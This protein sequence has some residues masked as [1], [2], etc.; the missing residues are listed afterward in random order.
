[1]ALRPEPI[2]LLHPDWALPVRAGF[3]CR[4]GGVSQGPY[5]SLNLGTH[6]GDD[7]QA[8]SENRRR[9]IAAAGLSAA[10]RWLSQVHGAQVVRADAVQSDRTAADAVWSDQPGAVCAVLVAD[11]VPILLAADQGECVAAVHAGWRGLVSGVI[12]QTLA[13]LPVTAARLQA[14]VGPCIGKAAYEVGPEVWQAVAGVSAA[15]KQTSAEKRHI[16]L[17][18]IAARRLQQA[19]VAQVQQAHACT[20]SNPQQF[21]SYRRDGVTG[22]SAAYIAIDL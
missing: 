9:L 5:A 6:V 15:S 19:G 10:P 3:S 14:W 16:D 7:A 1:M 2:E 17:S 18:L 21:F 8:V 11:C 4:G 20:A 22:R 12:E 13:A